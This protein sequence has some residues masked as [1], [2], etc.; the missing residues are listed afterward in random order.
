MIYYLFI[1]VIII[2]VSNFRWIIQEFLE[3]LQINN[4]TST[5]HLSIVNN[6]FNELISVQQFP[7]K[8]L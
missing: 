8:T 4:S 1:F 6:P 2:F 5:T 7:Q 3:I